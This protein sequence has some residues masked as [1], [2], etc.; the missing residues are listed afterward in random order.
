MEVARERGCGHRELVEV[1][2]V[3]RGEGDVPAFGDAEVAREVERLGERVGVAHTAHVDILAAVLKHRHAVRHGEGPRHLEG[4]IAIGIH[5]R[6]LLFLRAALRLLEVGVHVGIFG[7]GVLLV[8]I[9]SGGA[10][11]LARFAFEEGSPF[12]P[13]LVVEGVRQVLRHTLE[14]S[15]ASV[16]PFRAVAHHYVAAFVKLVGV[17]GEDGGQREGVALRQFEAET[18]GEVAPGARL[19][20]KV[21]GQR[22]AEFVNEANL[23]HARAVAVAPDLHLHVVRDGHT[24]H[25]LLFARGVAVEIALIGRVVHR[26][27]VA[28]GVRLDIAVHIAKAFGGEVGGV[29]DGDG[30][31]E[32]VADGHNLIAEE[33]GQGFVETIERCVHR[34]AYVP[35]VEVVEAIGRI[36]HF[37]LGL[38]VPT[39]LHP[40]GI[41][42]VAEGEVGRDVDILEQ[43]ERGIDGHAVLHT[44]AP[45]LHEVRLEELVLLR[46]DAVGELARVGERYL[47]VPSLLAH[48]TLA[49]EGV[50]TLERDGHVGQ[51]D[52]QRGVAHILRDI[53]RGRNGQADAGEGVGEAHRTGTGALAVRQGVVHTLQVLALVV[54][55]GKVDA[56]RERGVAARA[57][58]LRVGPLYLEA[59]RHHIVGH[60]LLAL[61]RADETGVEVSAESVALAVVHLAAQSPGAL[62]VDFAQGLEVHVVVDGEVVAAVAQVETANRFV[63]KG[64]HNKARRVFLGHPEESEGHEQRQGHILHDQVG[65]AKETLLA[66]NDLG[67]REFEAKVRMLGVAGGIGGVLEVE[68]TVVGALAL[69]ASQEAVAL[70]RTDVADEAL[71]RLEVEG[72]RFALVLFAALLVEG[73]ARERTCGIAVGIGIDHTAVHVHAHLG[74]V[75]LHALVVHLALAKEVGKARGG[76]VGHGVLGLVLDGRIDTRLALLHTVVGQ[77]VA[78]GAVDV[79]ALI[80][81]ADGAQQR[82]VEAGRV[83]GSAV[84]D[85]REHGRAVGHAVI[86]LLQAVLPQ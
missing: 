16:A 74:G 30:R 48:L 59:L 38:L 23:A 15:E 63:A 37:A 69:A 78:H 7:I 73:L 44:V 52:G 80:E 14:T 66:R 2:I 70:G 4:Q 83:D 34:D 57:A 49:A 67:A 17:G 26:G 79:E 45:V 64:G 61:H 28:V 62:R 22:A 24:E 1:E 35:V 82:G 20:C 32:D 12:A 25:T 51:G 60:I 55:G 33:F 42:D 9:C 72:H 76:I 46:G 27:Y 43:L 68:R 6:L 11:R 21:V 13:R 81:G 19:G 39:A 41:H 5:L 56:G 3:A 71:L 47:L 40:A 53:G 36:A 85:G 50:H 10:F 75:E 58:V 77:G 54:L 31:L 29:A 8:V 86:R 65:R 84:A 18:R